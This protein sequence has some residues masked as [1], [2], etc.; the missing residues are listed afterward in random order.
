MLLRRAFAPLL[1]AA[2]GCTSAA[3]PA[4]A[5]VPRPR[6]G[7]A[8][9]DRIAMLDA[10]F[11]ALRSDSAALLTL[12]RAMP[13]G[14]DLHSHLSG[15]VYAESYIRWAAED[16]LCYEVSSATLVAPPCGGLPDTVPAARLLADTALASRAIDAWSIRGWRRGEASG[17]E[18]FF[19][20][21]RRFGLATRE[22]FG[23]ML[24]E[25]TARA[26]AQRVGYL[27]LMVTLDRGIAPRLAQRVG[28]T[29]DLGAMEHR[30]ER[31]GLLDS[32][33][34]VPAMIDSAEARRRRL[35][36][37]GTAG[38][39]PG[40]RVV[41]RYLYQVIRA[42]PPEEVFAQILTGF[43]LTALDRRVVGLNLVAPED[44]PVAMRDFGLHMRII[45]RLHASRPDVRIALHAGELTDELVGSS[46][47]RTHIRESITI[48]H[49]SRIGHGVDLF[50]ERDP[51]SLLRLMAARR[52]L[53][54]I[55]LS[56]NDVILG[57]S[58]DRHPLRAY[59][60]HG[61]PVAF[62]TDD[63]GVSRSDMTH[64]LLRAVRDQ[65]MSYGELRTAVRNSIDHSFVE[66]SV[67]AR[68]QAELDAALNDFETRAHG[69]AD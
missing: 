61:V 55:G 22:R 67:K 4:P 12:L 10:R 9:P 45:D 36:R 63:E 14:G 46:A 56:S 21:F 50:N 47:P 13:K 32:L 60:G 24:A 2:L 3:P 59:L 48:G 52:V 49:A 66:D 53:V 29:P 31:A 28:W 34:L 18:H 40:C 11:A 64:E 51:A 57:V 39:N 33:R 62:V 37:C 20:T 7:A 5:P 68:L 17:H 26:A 30:L 6:E 42:G 1:I 16:G 25:V 15:A 69:D 8:A 65:G 43:H 41:V 19:A 58:G 27:E 23:D 54:E 44:G 38:E 35:L